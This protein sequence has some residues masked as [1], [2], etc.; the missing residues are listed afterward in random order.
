MRETRQIKILGLDGVTFSCVGPTLIVADGL[1]GRAG[2]SARRT[3]DLAAA[4]P[5]GVARRVNGVVLVVP[6]AELFGGAAEA[7][8]GAAD[9]ER[10]FL[11]AG[12]AIRTALRLGVAVVLAARSTELG[13]VAAEVILA[14]A[15]SIGARCVGVASSNGECASMKR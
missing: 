2:A 4:A 15:G 1:L 10:A 9:V 12:L 7:K 3:I 14:A 13:R 11:V 6:D 5:L 8:L